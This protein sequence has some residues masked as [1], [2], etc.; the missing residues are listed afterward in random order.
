M[1]L[2]DFS[3][4]RPNGELVM[5]ITNEVTATPPDVPNPHDPT[6]PEWYVFEL[7]RVKSR[8]SL[9]EVTPLYAKQRTQALLDIAKTEPFDLAR[10]REECQD[11]FRR[12]LNSPHLADQN[13]KDLKAMSA[14]MDKADALNATERTLKKKWLQL[15]D[16]TLKLQDRANENPVNFTLYVVRDQEHDDV[17]D[18]EE[19]H[20]SIFE[21]WNDP[22]YLYSLQLAPPGIGKTTALYGQNLW[23][24]KDDQTLRCLKVCQDFPTA[25]KRLGV[26]RRYIDHPRFKAIAPHVKIDK[27]LPDNSL[28]FTLIRVNIGS[29]DPSMSAAGA[30]TAVQGAGFD[31]IDPDDLCPEKVIREKSTRDAISSNFFNVIMERIRDLRRSRVRF[32]CTPWDPRDTAGQII[33]DVRSGKLAGWRI[34]SH[35]VGEDAAGVPIPNVTRPGL[36]QK[37]ITVKATQPRTYQFCHRLN[38]T[39]TELRTLSRVLYYDFYGGTSEMCP[40]SKREFWAQF[41]V[42]VEAGDKWQV[43]DPAA[44]G[45]DHTFSV[46]FSLS[47]NG[48]AVITN[49]RH[50]GVSATDSIPKVIA[51]VKSNA[52]DNVLIEA[53]GGMKGV[54]DIWGSMLIASLG[55][56]YRNRVFYSGT[57]LRDATGKEVGQNVN[58]QGRFANAA[59]YLSSGTI[60]F[61]GQW[62]MV[63]GIPVL[64]PVKD[65]GLGFLHD[66]LMTYPNCTQDDGID[67]FALFVNYHVG[68]LVRSIDGLGEPDSPEESHEK[69]INYLTVIYR[70]QMAQQKKDRENRADG[71]HN[72]EREF[73]A[74]A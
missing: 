22:D 18:F 25:K 11:P 59:P 46:G 66:Q 70:E 62:E 42:A 5:S 68:R 19:I 28:E 67:T 47:A 16:E 12:F 60:R 72:E 1:V 15:I 39:P 33:T 57:R 8:L 6:T 2:I 34:N 26:V 63:K 55:K 27:S 14:A 4:S 40:E 71:V 29:Q 24:F 61:P 56:H 53:A 74:V 73:F 51:M 65:D 38:P 36:Q 58:K 44:G 37:L 17:L 41:K 45:A 52:A 50:W 3:T 49:A 64:V 35:P 23:D 13:E 21:A 30:V 31:R 7:N 69:A 43:F 54:A 48:R 20:I 10:A 9:D 32:I